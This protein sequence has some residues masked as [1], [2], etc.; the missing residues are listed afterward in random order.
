LHIV[1]PRFGISNAFETSVMSKPL[2]IEVIRECLENLYIVPLKS[3]FYSWRLCQPVFVQPTI[4]TWVFIL[5]ML[6]QRQVKGGRKAS[7]CDEDY[8][9]SMFSNE[10]INEIILSRNQDYQHL[11]INLD[12][13]ADYRFIWFN[14]YPQVYGLYFTDVITNTTSFSKRIA[15][16]SHI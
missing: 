11:L 2:C 6:N 14:K 7:K 16:Y 3:R 8:I 9:K 5:K 10:I 1:L 13:F 12:I 4:Y 15:C